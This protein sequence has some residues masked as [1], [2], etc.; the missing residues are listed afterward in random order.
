[1]RH[2]SANTPLEILERIYPGYV[3]ALD[4]GWIET[5]EALQAK[6]F[7]SHDRNLS[8]QDLSNTL[9]IQT[10]ILL[11]RLAESYLDWL[12]LETS[13][14]EAFA[15]L[16]QKDT[17]CLFVDIRETWEGSLIQIPNV[18]WPQP[19]EIEKLKERALA[20]K[21]VFLYCHYGVRSRYVAAYLRD[22]GVHHTYSIRGGL[23]ALALC[24][25]PPLPRY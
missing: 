10:E 11:N 22:Q 13:P 6:A 16:N 15:K 4:E 1:M 23:H 3:N 25:D 5:A 14:E 9:G 24:F 7:Q 18:W 17:T 19:F 12:S 20:A 2:L 8:I 21:K